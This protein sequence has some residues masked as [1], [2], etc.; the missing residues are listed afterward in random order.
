MDHEEK[1]WEELEKADCQQH[2]NATLRFLCDGECPK[3][4]F[5]LK[6]CTCAPCECVQCMQQYRDQAHRRKREGFYVGDLNAS[7]AEK[8]AR[9]LSASIFEDLSYLKMQC[10]LRGT[11]I[12]NRWKKKTTKRREEILLKVDP[13]MYPRQWCEGHFSSE[14][15]GHAAMRW[16]QFP[17][18]CL[19]PYID[20]ESFKN[21]P[22]RFL[23]L[24]SARTRFHP[25]RWAAYDTERMKLQWEAGALE[26]IFNIGAIVMIEERY[27]EYTCWC[28]EWN[29][30]WKSVGFPRAKLVLDAQAYIMKILRG[31]VEDL[32]EGLLIDS[33]TAE[34]QTASLVSA[35][36]FSNNSSM[37]ISSGYLYQPFDKP[38]DLDVRRLLLIANTKRNLA[39]DHLWLLQTEPSYMRW[40]IDL[41][42]KAEPLQNKKN[43]DTYS[44][45]ALEIE[46]DMMRYWRWGNLLEEIQKL[47]DLFQPGLIS[48]DEIDPLIELQLASFEALLYTYLDLYARHLGEVVRLR[49][50]V[51]HHFKYVYRE[52]GMGTVR[53]PPDY[54]K[55]PLDWCLHFMMGSPFSENHFDYAMLFEY[56]HQYLLTSSKYEQ[57]RVDE[58][59]EHVLSDFAA[60]HEIIAMLRL[61]RP[62]VT[63][64]NALQNAVE[65]GY[66]PGKG[67][68]HESKKTLYWGP[69]DDGEAQ[70]IRA[71]KLLGDFHKL[72]SPVGY[73]DHSWLNR[74]E[75]QRRALTRYWST[76]RTQHR[77]HFTR[78]NVE[79]EEI[80]EDM[81]ILSADINK[82]HLA[83]LKLEREEIIANLH[84]TMAAQL[85]PK[86]STAVLQTQWG[87]TIRETKPSSEPKMKLKT[88][89][90]KLMENDHA[91]SIFADAT[92]LKPQPLEQICVHVK[93]RAMDIFSHMFYIGELG[94]K[95]V[96][97]DSFVL[98]M[99][100]AGFDAHHTGGSAVH[101]EPNRE[102]KWYGQGSIG[103]HRPHPVA[104][105]DPV[106]LRI[107]GKRMNKWFGWS[108][109]TFILEK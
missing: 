69:N 68:R 86:V 97:W 63:Q 98:A 100:E 60:M 106:M 90:E 62:R 82:G 53:E 13:K 93:K 14:L 8:F 25:S 61:H 51:S 48:S 31:V 91:A 89:P 26:V 105:V 66:K 28:P 15:L 102:S 34:D 2:V 94:S 80:D 50:G 27:G 16:R 107:F 36:R 74:D 52:T 96:A 103:F 21:D 43:K 109:D 23:N 64:I 6:G 77:I 88:R 57:R 4:A 73:R 67:W 17:N 70:L 65:H 46:Q 108:K 101:F 95:M 45:L 55:D 87:P 12:K 33:G 104:I 7:D 22:A 1:I 38:L 24:L 75:A 35:L 54:T 39:G 81:E 71:S 59:L 40:Y 32:V 49:P 19:V 78:K 30:Q 9:S 84:A 44:H 56:L 83:A 11:A 41:I 29:H 72:P 5:N 85:K 79:K 76:I 37:E 3:P 20:L 42:L 99:L 10:S 58:L 92:I 47:N 18:A